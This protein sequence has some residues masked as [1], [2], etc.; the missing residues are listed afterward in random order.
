MD[1]V[2]RS[3]VSFAACADWCVLTG[4][5]PQD[6]KGEHPIT[7]YILNVHHAKNVKTL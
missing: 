7:P 3:L 1:L 2:L 6:P 5:T 4:R